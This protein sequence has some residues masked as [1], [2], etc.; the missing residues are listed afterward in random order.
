VHEQTLTVPL[1]PRRLGGGLVLTARVMPAAYL[2]LTVNL[3]LCLARLARG[4]WWQDDLNLLARASDGLSLSLLFSDYNGHLVPGTWAM[5]A[6]FNGIAPLQWWPAAVVTL[7]LV[8]AIGF[9]TLALL[10]RLFGTR[11]AILVPFAMVCATSLTLTSTLWWAASLQWL[12]VTLSLTAGLWFHVGYL[13]TGRIRDAA[14]AVLSV[15][16]GLAFF[17]KAL[18]TV[19]VMAVFTVLYGVGGPLLNRPWRAIREYFGYWAAH[20]AVTGGFLAL[21]LARVQVETGP[22]VTTSDTVTT[23]RWMLLDTLLPSFVGGPLAW[24]TTPKT[25]INAWPH[26]LP[27]VAIGAWVLTAL[28]IAGSVRARRGAWRAWTLLGAFLVVS[29]GLVVRAR[30]GFIGPFVGRDQRYLTDLA[31]LAPLCLALAWLPLRSGVDRGL[32]SDPDDLASHPGEVRGPRQAPVVAGAL[33]VVLMTVGG[34]V[35]GETFMANWTKNPTQP[36]LENLQ[37]GLAGAAPATVNLLPESVVPDLIMTPTFEDDRRLS[38]VTRPMAVRPA[39][40][41][42][43][44]SYSLVDAQGRVLPGEVALTPGNQAEGVEPF[45][46]ATAGRN[47]VVVFAAE[48]PEWRWVVR[49]DYLTESDAT[50]ELS[51]GSYPPVPIRMRGGLHTMYVDLLG[52]GSSQLVLSGVQPGVTICIGKAAIAKEL[53]PRASS[54]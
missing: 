32:T 29:I 35:S 11:P 53:T 54:R 6:L 39:F 43:T 34:A 12:P 30:L 9:S 28:A 15:V 52:G 21:Y 41:P 3:L 33:A 51:L 31:V 37:Q 38:N 7:G 24:Y 20:A 27:F 1:A 4:Y 44:D 42:Y 36:Y 19:L 22:P 5:A 13:Q 48:Q 50:A 40:P 16:L 18:T 25:T 47:A 45:N 17:E 46:C 2:I 8:A 10:R 14:G 23:I 26:P 49:L